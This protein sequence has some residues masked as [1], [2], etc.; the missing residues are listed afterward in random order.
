MTPAALLTDLQARSV[1]L[2][3]AGDELRYKAKAGTM[4]PDL[5]AT[6]K[7][8]KPALIALLQEEEA[9]VSWRAEAMREQIPVAGPVPFLAA[10]SN[11]ALVPDVCL[12]CGE[13]FTSTGYVQ[14]CH[15]CT[16]AANRVLSRPVDVALAAKVEMQ[17]QPPPLDLF[18]SY[19]DQIPRAS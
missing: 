7:P 18:T 19:P 10:V 13:S 8:H 16:V 12:S 9:A 4:T 1:R 3:L 5:A 6:I 14:R 15:L 11:V 2:Y 17:G